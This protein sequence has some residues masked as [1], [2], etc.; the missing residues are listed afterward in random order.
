[1]TQLQTVHTKDAPKAVGAYSQAVKHQGMLYTSGQIGLDP[2]SG[3]MVAD[4]VVNQTKQVVANLTAVIEAAGGQ[5]NQI[6]KVTIFLENMDDF[7]KVNQIYADWLGEHRPAR[8]TVA[9][10]ALPLAA[11]VEMDCVVAIG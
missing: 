11:K 5:L 1:M 8:S 6:V 10:A 9:V 3:H 7:P 4:D 2:T